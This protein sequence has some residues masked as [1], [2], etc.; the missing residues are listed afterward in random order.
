MAKP[1]VHP[2]SDLDA[3]RQSPKSRRQSLPQPMTGFAVTIQS[4]RR[5]LN[6][7]KTLVFGSDGGKAESPQ[8]QAFPIPGNS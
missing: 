5:D 8:S 6:S 2:M 4:G 3:H 7:G 1:T